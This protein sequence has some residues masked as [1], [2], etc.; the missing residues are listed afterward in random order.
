[1]VQSCFPNESTTAILHNTI[2][3]ITV[4]QTRTMINERSDF[5]PGFGFK[6]LGFVFFKTFVV[7]TSMTMCNVEEGL[8]NAESTSMTICLLC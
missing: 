1:M 3:E 7:F 2:N 4:M 6:V 5:F 8:K